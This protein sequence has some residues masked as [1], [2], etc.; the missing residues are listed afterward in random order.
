[1]TNDET[2][3]PFTIENKEKNIILFIAILN[4]ILPPLVFTFF[5]DIGNFIESDINLKI[6]QSPNRFFLVIPSIILIIWFI[7]SRID[8]IEFWSKIKDHDYLNRHCNILFL[9]VLCF[10]LIGPNVEMVGIV[11]DPFIYVA[12]WLMIVPILSVINLPLF[13]LFRNNLLKIRARIHPDVHPISTKDIKVYLAYSSY[14]QIGIG[15]LVALSLILPLTHLTGLETQINQLVQNAIIFSILSAALTLYA[16]YLMTQQT[17]SLQSVY[18]ASQQAMH[19][20]AIA[21]E[22]KHRAE[23]IAA[24]DRQTHLLELADTLEHDIDDSISSL[25]HASNDLIDSSKAVTNSSTII[26][27]D[28][29][30]L[31]KSVQSTALNLSQVA[32]AIIEFKTV[33]GEISQQTEKTLQGISTATGLS[34]QANTKIKDLGNA[35]ATIGQVIDNIRDIAQKTNMLALNASIEA[36]RAGEA[37]RGFAVVA[38]EVKALASATAHATDGIQEQI[39]MVQQTSNASIHAVEKVDATLASLDEVSRAV[40]VAIEE[41]TAAVAEIS[42][43]VTSVESE[44][45]TLSSRSNTIAEATESGEIVAQDLHDVALILSDKSQQIQEKIN[46]FVTNLRNQ[47]E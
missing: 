47:K 31:N 44:A 42:I 37:G 13:I 16:K 33:V 1:M 40:G 24:R 3:P 17:D 38:N 18:D 30:V 46:Q 8:K 28:T 35:S 27:Q 23:E 22:E 6:Q 5:R 15:V 7:K 43:S 41:L 34:V 32:S 14:A 10:C 45:D 26:K 2:A 29:N 20:L 12:L 9:A 21:T 39:E 4:F 36:Q 25:K 11:T 19:Q